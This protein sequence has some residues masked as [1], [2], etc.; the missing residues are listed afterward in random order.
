MTKK[1]RQKVK[2]EFDRLGSIEFGSVRFWREWHLW[3]YAGKVHHIC[4][5][6]ERHHITTRKAA[7]L[8]E[9]AVQWDGA[10]KM[11]EPP[12]APWK[13]YLSAEFV[14]RSSERSK[15]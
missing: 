3:G 1:Q 13:E 5:M 9:F 6:A 4:Q 11:P 8:I 10:E 14:D 2:A 12:P 7:E 15:P